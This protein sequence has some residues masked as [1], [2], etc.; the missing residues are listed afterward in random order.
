MA[1]LYSLLGICLCA[2]LLACGQA[3][4]AP[5]AAPAEPPAT[6]PSSTSHLRLGIDQW[7]GYYPA[8]LADELGYF[9]NAG[10]TVELQLPGDTD[11]MLAEFAA[12]EY[13]MIGVALGDLI[14]LSRQ[15]EDVVVLLV[16][17]QSAGGDALLAAPGFEIP[18]SGPVRIGTN[19]GGFGELFIR[20]LLPQMAIDPARVEWINIDASSV[21]Q[22]LLSKQI[23]LGHC[24][25][26]YASQ[27]EALGATRRFSS[28]D[29]PGLIP[30]V[31]AA[32]RH[33]AD[34][35]PAA[36]RAFTDGWFRAVDWWRSHP[37]QAAQLIEQR[38]ALP[39]GGAGLTGIELQDLAAN[40]RLLGASGAAELEPVIDRYSEF[41]VARGRLID[42]IQA[43]EM[44]IPELLP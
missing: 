37:E 32:T 44:L 34:A 40:Q 13:D 26:P 4:E 16:S 22:A 20:E 27:A 43:K 23:D 5:P 3:P 42:P 33:A 35:N 19:L 17:D 21:P 2:L 28:A 6:A 8:V 30:D 29:T 41:F 15:R 11:R 38:L 31:I 10:L 12:G 25:E 36:Y 39:A 1:K 7:P 9:A 14:T 24:W 18:S